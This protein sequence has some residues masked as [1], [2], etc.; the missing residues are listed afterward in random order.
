MSVEDD[1][2]VELIVI[3]ECIFRRENEIIVLDL[4]IVYLLELE[5][6]IVRDVEEMFM[7]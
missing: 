2:L 4:S 3:F 5:D 1:E 6:E 7:L